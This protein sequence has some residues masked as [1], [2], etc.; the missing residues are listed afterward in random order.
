MLLHG[1]TNYFQNQFYSVTYPECKEYICKSNVGV[2]ESLSVHKRHSMIPILEIQLAVNRLK[3]VGRES[4]IIFF[5]HNIDIQ[6]IGQYFD[7]I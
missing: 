3:T 5:H 2:Y 6:G 7:C 4:S 1:R